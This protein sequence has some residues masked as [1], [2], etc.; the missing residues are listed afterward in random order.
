MDDDAVIRDRVAAELDFDPSVRSSGIAVAVRDGIVSLFGCAPSH[1]DKIGA[2]RAAHRVEGVR[3]VAV[4]MAVR[5]PA[6][7]V[8]GNCEIANEAKAVL[9]RK[10]CANG[11]WV[12]VENCWITLT[13][14]ADTQDQ[15]KE[16]ERLVRKLQGVTGVTNELGLACD[17]RGIELRD[18]IV[19]RLHHIGPAVKSVSVEVEGSTVRLTGEVPTLLLPKDAEAAA[20]ATPGVTNVLNRLTAR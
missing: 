20:W 8:R 15:R 5:L 3:G 6:D 13:G 18:R 9:V 1:A 19:N 17:P 11:V 7:G 12:T 4:E 2:V 14:C 10:G 16:I